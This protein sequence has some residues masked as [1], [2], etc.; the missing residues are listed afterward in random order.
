MGIPV[1]H[2]QT[3]ERRWEIL[4]TI[5]E[6]PPL[7]PKVFLSNRD[8]ACQKL[9]DVFAG[10]TLQLKVGTHYPEQVAN[11]VAAYLASLD[12]EAKIETLGRCLF[13][14]DYQAWDSVTALSGPLILVADFDFEFADSTA[15]ISLQNARRAGHVVIFSG[16]PGGIPHPNQVSIPELREYQLKEALVN[17]G[18]Q[19]ER[20]RVLAPE[21]QR[22]LGFIASL[23]TTPFI[24]ARMGARNNSG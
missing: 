18:Y 24:F 5:G 8:N 20:A 10:I 4:K 11:F 17:A 21:K 2:V 22:Q 15:A 1:Q 13:V 3:P 7:I 14:T 9:K 6:P 16:M 23:L 12:G 19:E